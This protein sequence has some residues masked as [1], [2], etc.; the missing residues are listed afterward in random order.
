M[1]RAGEIGERLK[2]SSDVALLG[3]GWISERSFY[4]ALAYEIGAPYYDGAW[5]VDPQTDYEAAILHGFARLAP[6]PEGCRA[7]VAPRSAALRLLLESAARSSSR[8]PLAI[9]SR[10]R[11]ATCLRAQFGDVMAERS[12]NLVADRDPLL[13]AKTRASLWQILVVGAVCAAFAFGV[14]LAPTLLRVI[15]SFT[16]WIVFSGAVW[17]RS[18]AIAAR[19][20]AGPQSQNT[21]LGDADLPVYTVIAPLYREGEVAAQLVG[22]LGRL[23]YPGIMAQPP[24]EMNPLPPHISGHGRD[25]HSYNPSIQANGNPRLDLAL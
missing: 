6:N 17:L 22:A 12:A 8:M 25:T 20:D 3:E 7:V 11:L 5:L 19:K 16:F 15:F 2:V 24:Q 10:Q 21:K 4:M 14:A 23:D 18:M 1:I 9:A 13:S